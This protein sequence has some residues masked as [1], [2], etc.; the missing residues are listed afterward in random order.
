MENGTQLIDVTEFKVRF[1]RLYKFALNFT[2][3]PA[4]PGV[5]NRLLNV[6]PLTALVRASKEASAWPSS[7]MDRAH[8]HGDLLCYL[9]ESWP[10]RRSPTHCLYGIDQPHGH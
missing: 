10:P 5:V 4:A 1:A 9:T 8:F 3:P 2:N 7:T 6:T